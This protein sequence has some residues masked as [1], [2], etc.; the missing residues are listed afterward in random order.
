M[1]SVTCVKLP[2]AS[3]TCCV[4]LPPALMDAT[5]LRR[6]KAVVIERTSVPHAPWVLVE[7]NDKYWARAKVLSTLVEALKAR[8][9]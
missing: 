1:G 3:N 7:A 4:R 5:R 8:L 6:S 9:G 2:T